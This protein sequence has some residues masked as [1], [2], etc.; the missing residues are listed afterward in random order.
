MKIVSEQPNLNVVVGVD[1]F[2]A[3]VKYRKGSLTYVVCDVKPKPVRVLIYESFKLTAIDEEENARKKTTPER[4]AE[5]EMKF[6]GTNESEDT[7]TKKK[8]SNAAN[9]KDAAVIT[10][11]EAKPYQSA[12]KL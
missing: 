6:Y 12:W 5:A 3:F 2:S 4:V 7:A 1:D 8:K 10:K 11:W 9:K